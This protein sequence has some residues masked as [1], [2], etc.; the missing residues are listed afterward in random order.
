MQTMRVLNV[1]VLL[2]PVTGGG[3][4]ER[5]FQMSQSLVRAGVECTILSTD[6]GITAERTQQLGDVRLITL[7]CI[8]KRFFIV[9][10]SWRH[11]KDLVA[12]VDVIHLMGHWSMLNM[13][14]AFMARQTGTPYVVCP[15]GE[16]SLFG[17]SRWIKQLFNFIVGRRILR[18]AAGHIAVTPDEITAYERY[19]IK[20]QQVKVIPNGINEVDFSVDR[21]N[22]FKDRFGFPSA[23]F[24]L[25]M[26]RLNP[27]KGPD[28]LLEAFCSIAHKYSELHLVFAGPDGGLLDSLKMMT[29]EQGL[30]DRVHFIGYVSGHDKTHAYRAAEFLVI[31][32]RL[33][34]MS[35]V[36]LE[37]GIVGTPVLLTDR[38]GFDAVATVDGGQIVAATANDLATGLESMLENPAVLKTMGVRL[39]FHVRQ[40]FIWEVIVEQLV[41]LYKQIVARKSKE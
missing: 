3:T 10:F 21:V 30:T 37:A 12:S 35:I 14:V 31:P 19:G 15:A 41:D 18:E 13:L 33:E 27:I 20:A 39:Q 5:T 1:T 17:R 38:C 22:Q 8:W 9:R 24:I 16:L 32:S 40:N 6:I 7:P 25:F 29:C 4:A 2:D 34:A 11:L 28:L 26:G 23:P 36:V